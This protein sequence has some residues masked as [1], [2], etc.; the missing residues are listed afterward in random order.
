VAET[1][2]V[3]QEEGKVRFEK[4]LEERL[5]IG[6]AEEERKKGRLRFERKI[7]LK[8]RIFKLIFEE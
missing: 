4:C 2:D 5:E 7:F 6:L 8:E 3:L 1:T